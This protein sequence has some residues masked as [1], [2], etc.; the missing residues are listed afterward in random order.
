[1]SLKSGVVSDPHHFDIM[2]IE[3][4]GDRE[5]LQVNSFNWTVSQLCKYKY[6]KQL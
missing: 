5:K 4:L 6:I 1:M 2:H 3:V